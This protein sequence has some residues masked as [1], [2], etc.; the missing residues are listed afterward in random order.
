M[1]LEANEYGLNRHTKLK[2]AEQACF[3]IEMSR[4][5]VAILDDESIRGLGRIKKYS[6]REDV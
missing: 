1:S 2:L 4:Y 5:H 6:T 3:A